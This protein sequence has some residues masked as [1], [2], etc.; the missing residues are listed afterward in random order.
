MTG[1][2]AI[3]LQRHV[4]GRAGSIGS[5]ALLTWRLPMQP[6]QHKPGLGMIEAAGVFPVLRLVALQAV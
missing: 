5:M 4:L 3:E 6:G 2:T 1:R